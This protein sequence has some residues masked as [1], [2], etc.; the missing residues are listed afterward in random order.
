MSNEILEAT[1][2]QILETNTHQEAK[3]IPLIAADTKPDEAIILPIQEKKKSNGWKYVA[4]AAAI[5]LLF[6]SYWIPAQT[7]FIDTGKIQ[8]A[9]F[10]PI[11]QT[12]QRVFAMRTNVQELPSVSAFPT[13]EELTKT[14]VDSDASVFNYQLDEDFFIPILL[15][16]TKTSVVE[17]QTALHLPETSSTTD[18]SY[19]LIGGCFSIK[20][21][22]DKFVMELKD[23]GFSASILD[24]E[25]GL[26]RV[27]AGS[28]PT[29]SDADQNLSNFVNQGFSGW[30]LKK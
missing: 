9:D 13:W 7:D 15:D 4:A 19:H 26:Y 22:A 30:I 8:L 11:H 28:Y 20:E 17:D 23:K 12:P 29:S 24:V 3:I 6:Y 14:V 16:K 21:N 18:N 25:N 1:E 5:P 10:N 2:S 27:T